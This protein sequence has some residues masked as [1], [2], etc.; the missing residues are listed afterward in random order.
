MVVIIPTAERG[1]HQNAT[2]ILNPARVSPLRVP[3][4]TIRRD[5]GRIRNAELHFERHL[6]LRGILIVGDPVLGRTLKLG[7]FARP[8]N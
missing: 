5:A 7:K 6:S 8:R 1:Q 2:W 4:R 3:R